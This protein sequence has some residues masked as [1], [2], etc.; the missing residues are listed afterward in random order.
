MRKRLRKKL[1]CRNHPLFVEFYAAEFGIMPW[2][3]IKRVERTVN[4]PYFSLSRKATAMLDEI[5][6]SQR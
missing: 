4:R 5:T 2:C 1:L 3:R 6:F